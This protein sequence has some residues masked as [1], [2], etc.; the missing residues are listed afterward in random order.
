MARATWSGFLSFGLVSAPVGLYTATT[1]Q[2]IHFNQLHQRT[3]NRVRYKKVDEET[4][5]ELST[6]DIVNGYPVG[7]G[8]YIVVTREEMKAAAPGKSDLIEIQDF[9][10]LDDIDPK[11]FRQTY[12]LSPKGKAAERPYTLLRQAMR[13][14]NKVRIGF[15]DRD[16]KHLLDQ[17]MPL[18]QKDSPFT[19]RFSPAETRLAHFVRPELV[20]EVQF[21][22]W[23]RDAHLRH[24]SWRGL[25]PDKNPSEVIRES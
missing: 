3:S 23:T 21:G 11:F 19:R 4:G 5:E 14:S 24:P 1:D 15:T 7:G 10:D 13:E 8:E 22:E 20:G 12:Y 9:V 6:D 18:A 25:R 2:T 17:L 16:R